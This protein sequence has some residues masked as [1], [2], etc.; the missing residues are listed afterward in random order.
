[1]DLPEL[2][3]E[4]VERTGDSGLPTRASLYL[5]L[6]EVDLKKRLRIGANETV[7]T[8]TTDASGNVNLPADYSELRSL[9]IAGMPVRN[10][11]LPSVEDKL[12]PGYTI[13][14]H[15]LQTTYA[16][17][18]VTLHYYAAIP[19]LQTTGTNWLIVAEP[20]VY[21]Y[22]MMRQ[23]YLAKLDVEKAQACDVVLSNLIAE[24]LRADRIKRF[25]KLPYRVAGVNP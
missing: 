23:V 16:N 9:F 25:G 20:E 4:T 14:G 15:Q 3:A 1:M 24:I 13:Q 8:L 12:T 7:A 22:A 2:I 11:A 10:T 5:Q 6:A 17:T 21:I 18:P 19:T